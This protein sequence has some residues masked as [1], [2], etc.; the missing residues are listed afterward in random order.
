[1][2][3]EGLG[4]LKN[5]IGN[6]TRDHTVCSIVPQPS[7]LPHDPVFEVHFKMKYFSVDYVFFLNVGSG[8]CRNFCKHSVLFL[9]DLAM[10]SV[11]EAVRQH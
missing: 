7:T 10:L 11:A 3:L 5:P 8:N 9:L 1:V 6:R 2:R 4:Q